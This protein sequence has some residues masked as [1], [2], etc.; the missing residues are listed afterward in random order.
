MASTDTA[1]RFLFEQTDIRGELVTL[2]QSYQ[3]ALAAHN[4]PEPIRNLLGE[5]AASALLLASTLKFSGIMTLQARSEGDLKLLM[6]ECRDDKSFRAL[7][8][9]DESADLH[10]A[11]LAT[12]MPEGQMLISIDPTKGRRYQ[13][14]VALAGENLAQCFEA[15][16]QQSEQLPTRIWLN[17]NAERAAGL[18]LQALPA[19]IEQDAE[20]RES[21]WAHLCTLTGTLKAEEQLSLDHETILTRLFH[22]DPLRLME[23]EA[24]QFSCSCSRGRCEQALASLDR[25][26]LEELIEEQGEIRM[27]CQFCNHP[28]RFEQSDLERIFAPAQP[29][30]H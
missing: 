16:F 10:N 6:V 20:S 9:W 3:E 24:V 19:S 2:E 7:A 12:L 5:L 29:P 4:Y 28:Y 14:V 1:Q 23:P 8:R 27:D 30:L 25:N 11:N 18:L 13:G 26:E 21:S 15:Y 22:Q 17:A